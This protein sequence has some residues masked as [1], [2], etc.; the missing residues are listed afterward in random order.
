MGNPASNLPSLYTDIAYNSLETPNL[1]S[2]ES[3]LK[4]DSRVTCDNIFAKIPLNLFQQ[5]LKKS[6]FWLYNH[7]IMSG[8]NVQ[9]ILL[10]WS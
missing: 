1:I 8:E 9:I 4:C 5:M 2:I 6:Y 7:Q 10:S 3:D